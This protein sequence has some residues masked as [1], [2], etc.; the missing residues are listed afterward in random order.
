MEIELVI[1]V[2]TASSGPSVANNPLFKSDNINGSVV[3]GSRVFLHNGG[4]DN[5]KSHYDCL[6]WDEVLESSSTD[7]IE[8]LKAVDFSSYSQ[9]MLCPPNHPA[10]DGQRFYVDKNFIALD[11][12]NVTDYKLYAKKDGETGEAYTSKYPEDANVVSL[13]TT[14]CLIYLTA[15][16]HLNGQNP[17]F[18]FVSGEVDRFKMFAT[19]VDPKVYA[20]NVSGAHNAGVAVAYIISQLTHEHYLNSEAVKLAQHV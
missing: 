11:D 20:Q 6:C 3:M 1:A 15:K 14:H 9:L 17:P 13:D 5:S 8:K 2:G 7:F 4:D 10:P 18:M 12:V 19:D 16:K